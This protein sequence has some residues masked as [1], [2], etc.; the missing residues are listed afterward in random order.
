MLLFLLQDAKSCRVSDNKALVF[1]SKKGHR[2]FGVSGLGPADFRLG[3]QR[4][5]VH[6]LR[7]CK[8]QVQDC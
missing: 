6:R 3:L 2:D 5:V 7:H 8:P 4:V 1:R